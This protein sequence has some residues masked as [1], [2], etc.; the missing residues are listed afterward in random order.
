MCT[1]AEMG[2][3]VREMRAAE[4]IGGEEEGLVGAEGAESEGVKPADRP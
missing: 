2:D 3:L 4:A 1:L